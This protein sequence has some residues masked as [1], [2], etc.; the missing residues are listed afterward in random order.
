MTV[1]DF[2]HTVLGWPQ[3]IKAQLLRV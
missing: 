3:L 1:V 2:S